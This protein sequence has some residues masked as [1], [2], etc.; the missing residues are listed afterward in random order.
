MRELN[1]EDSLYVAQLDSEGRC[2]WS[3]AVPWATGGVFIQSYVWNHWLE[4]WQHEYFYSEC[5]PNC[6]THLADLEVDSNGDVQKRRPEVWASGP[7]Y[8]PQHN[9]GLNQWQGS[10]EA[11]N[12]QGDGTKEG[13]WLPAILKCCRSKKSKDRQVL[14]RKQHAAKQR[15]RACETLVQAKRQ[16]KKFSMSVFCS[17]VLFYFSVMRPGRTPNTSLCSFLWVVNKIVL[18]IFKCVI[19]LSLKDVLTL[20]FDKVCWFLLSH[21]EKCFICILKAPKCSLKITLDGTR[22][23]H[24]APS[25]HIV[26]MIRGYARPMLQTDTGYARQPSCVPERVVSVYLR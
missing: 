6:E 20:I 9:V 5:H 22:W 25:G 7:K 14:A 18:K 17:F 23:P 12:H 4:K 10:E 8:V 2:K 21:T 1:E 26:L 16:K 15:K 3:W 13:V 19:S 11:G 24:T